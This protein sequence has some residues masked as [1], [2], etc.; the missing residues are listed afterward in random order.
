MRQPSRIQTSVHRE[1]IHGQSSMV[2]GRV[3]EDQFSPRDDSLGGGEFPT[4]PAYGP[5]SPRCREWADT[6]MKP[7]AD[8]LEVCRGC[9]RLADERACLVVCTCVVRSE[10][11]GEGRL[12]VVG[13]HADGVVD[14]LG[15]GS[16][17]D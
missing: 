9:G 1:I 6:D 10:Q 13:S 5:G 14:A 8:N 12:A 2:L 11:A 17:A 15:F 3:N 16:E 7:A 4:Q